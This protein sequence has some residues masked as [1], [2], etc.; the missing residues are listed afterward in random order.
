MKSR[1]AFYLPMAV[2]QF[3]AWGAMFA[4]WVFAFP[5]VR[6]ALGV[7]EAGAIRWVGLGLAVYVSLASLINFVLPRIYRQLG[8]ALTHAVALAFGG[9][10]I[11]LI[12]VAHAPLVL[13]CGYAVMSFGWASLSSTPYTMVTDRV[14]D[15]RYDLAMARFNF[16]VVVPQIGI[17]LALGWLVQSVAPAQAIFA[18]GLAM[19]LA[20]AMTLLLLRNEPRA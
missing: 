3:L 13:L 6:Q 14:T 7:D 9:F 16:S 15:G 1:L 8:K 5:H 10:G 4:V 12:A 19:L 2:A 11:I 18:G 20:A 17:A